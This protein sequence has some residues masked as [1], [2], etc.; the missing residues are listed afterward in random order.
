MSKL[1]DKLRQRLQEGRKGL[2]VYVTAGYPD[3]E[4]TFA[5]VVAAAEAGAD[6]VELG[7]PFSDPIADGPV[8]Q[9]A[10]TLALQAGATTAK[11]LDVIKKIAAQIDVPLAVMTYVNTILSYGV[12]EFIADV[13]AAGVSGVIVPDLPLE[14]GQLLYDVCQHHQVDL[15]QFI[16]PT[17]TPERI[18]EISELARGFIYCISTTGVTGVQTVDYTPVIQAIREAKEVT[19]IPVAIGFGIGSPAAAREAACL[20]DAV[21]VGSAIVE[22]LGQEGVAGMKAFILAIRQEMDREGE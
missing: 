13:A 15:I 20:G 11:T 3:Y 14:E 18:R 21:I 22:R 7:I 16:A 5:A 10:A 19:D 8:I 1:T 17:S 12:E 6:V 9:K 4:A 2:I